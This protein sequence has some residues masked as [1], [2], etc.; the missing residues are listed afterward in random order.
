VVLYSV[1]YRIIG[2]AWIRKGL[3]RTA[4]AR[5]ALL[6][7]YLSR[8]TEKRHENSSWTNILLCTVPQ[9]TLPADK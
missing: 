6:S 4:F 8:G 1:E 7:G 9:A 3:K 5:I 2:E